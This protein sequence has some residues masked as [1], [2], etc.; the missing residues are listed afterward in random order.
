V[1]IN[2]D[3][4]PFDKPDL[5]RVLSL[6][7]DRKAFVDILNQGDAPL[8]GIME[9]G[10]DGFW[11]LPPDMLAQVPGYGPDVAGNREEAR[12]IMKRLGYGP[13]K[14]LPLKVSTRGISI[15]KDPAVIM[16][17]Q[18]KEVWIDAEVE[19]VETAQWFVRVNKRAYSVGLNVTG[20][21]VDDPDQNFYEN[22]ACK[23]ER[24]Y[25]GYCNPEIEKLFDLQSVEPDIAKRQKLVWEIDRKLLEDGARPIIMWNRASICMQPYVKGYVASVNSVYNGFRFED[26]WLDK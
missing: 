2:R 23:S 19:I 24:N 3:A 8:G 26:V 9:P 25:P 12:A 16:A 5:R 1:I 14:H 10:P 4:P 22:F 21:G 7:L 15:F 17:G 13:D 20:N 11:G 18:L 6:A